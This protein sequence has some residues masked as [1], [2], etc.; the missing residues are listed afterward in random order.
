MECLSCPASLPY[1]LAKLGISR[2][3]VATRNENFDDFDKNCKKSP[4]G[5]FTETPIFP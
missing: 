2:K 1:D 3:P 4:L 5:H